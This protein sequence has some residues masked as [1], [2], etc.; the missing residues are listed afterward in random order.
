MK[1][2]APARII[3]ISSE[4]PSSGK[5]NFADLNGTRKYSALAAY[6]QSKLAN[7]MFTYE[8]ARLLAGSGVTVNAVHPG[9]VRTNFAMDTSGAFGFLARLARPFE[10]TPER[11]AETAIYLASSPEV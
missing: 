1:A 5:I 3:N 9:A 2:S 4:A 6:A 11:G 7:M 10:R 8:L